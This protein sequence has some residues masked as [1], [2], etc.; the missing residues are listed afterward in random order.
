MVGINVKFTVLFLKAIG[1]VIIPFHYVLSQKA[2]WAK[3]TQ[4]TK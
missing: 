3:A 1:N 4:K 2:L